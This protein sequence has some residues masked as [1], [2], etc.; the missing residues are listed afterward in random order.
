M[1]QLDEEEIHMK[2]LLDVHTHTTESGHAYS[3]LLEN[4]TAAKEQGLLLYGVSD[5]GPALP[6]GAHKFYFQ[7]MRV[8]PREIDGMKLLRGAE[9]NI[10]DY[11]GNIDMI[12]D[13]FHFLDYVIA[14][15]HPPCLDYGT[16]EENTKAIIGAIKNPRV[17]ILG[18]PDDGRYELDYVAVVKAAKENNCIIELNNSSLNPTGFRANAK[19]NIC[20]YLQLCKEMGVAIVVNSDAHFSLDVG[21]FEYAKPILEEIDFPKELIMNLNPN[22]FLE[23]I[24]YNQ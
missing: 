17:K 4:I 24:E 18:H 21:V 23:F 16:K 7:N 11:E 9:A 14:S 22:K 5:H 3:T 20:N 15:L 6:G 12:E 19:E 1:F 13:T 10:I 2:F 8:L